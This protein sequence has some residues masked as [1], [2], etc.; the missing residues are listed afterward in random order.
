MQTGI[1]AKNWCQRGSGMLLILLALSSFTGCAEDE[2]IDTI[3]KDPPDSSK[4]DCE[5]PANAD[6]DVCIVDCDDP[7]NADE[8]VCIVDCDDLANADVNVCIVDC[9]DPANADEDVCAIDCDDLANADENVCTIDCEDPANA[10]EEVC[11][12]EYARLTI[13]AVVTSKIDCEKGGVKIISGLDFNED[14]E[15][16]DDEIDF[17]SIVCNA[18]GG[19]LRTKYDDADAETCPTGGVVISS[20]ID[21]NENGELDEDEVEDEIIHCDAN[22]KTCVNTAPLMVKGIWYEAPDPYFSA[23]RV[24]DAKVLLSR[25]IDEE[26]VTVIQGG[27]S[28]I[29][30]EKFG[31]TID[32]D[33]LTVP[34]QPTSAM[35]NKPPGQLLIVDGCGNSVVTQI[36]FQNGADTEMYGH[37]RWDY[38]NGSEVKEYAVGDTF[39]VCWV[40]SELRNCRVESSEFGIPDW[41]ENVTDDSGC[42]EFEL[43]NYNLSSTKVT[44]VTMSCGTGNGSTILRPFDQDFTPRVIAASQ[45]TTEKLPSIGGVA[46][47]GLNAQG[48][49]SCTATSPSGESVEFP[50]M[51]ALVGLPYNK[52]GKWTVE[53]LGKDGKTYSNTSSKSIAVG[54][55]I[56]AINPSVQKEGADLVVTVAIEAAGLDGSCS[57]KFMHGDTEEQVGSL[58]LN[59]FGAAMNRRYRANGTLVVEGG[60]ALADD[61]GSRS[62]SATCISEDEAF[63]DTQTIKF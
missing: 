47:I 46:T 38:E 2:G 43:R 32:G 1:F 23:Q 55:S 29:D 7:A 16:D 61:A 25:D 5:D 9:D 60:A 39:R 31:Y 15:L 14:G 3:K 18:N 20:G 21:T 49:A 27:T 10:D 40:S 6:E 11:A 37:F 42:H 52:S 45:F 35:A 54:D 26:A 13:E 28:F 51:T 62:L 8:D 12:P 30:K 33:V 53:C 19:T 50:T 36:A 34:F 48:M 57:A 58:K 22:G 56:V 59:A 24:Y 44:K 4:I 17:K 41:F 63:Q